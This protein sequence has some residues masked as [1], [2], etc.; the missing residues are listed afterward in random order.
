MPWGSISPLGYAGCCGLT[1]FREAIKPV[2]RKKIPI[3][4]RELIRSLNRQI[5]Q[6]TQQARLQLPSSAHE[7]KRLRGVQIH[8]RNQ[9]RL[10]SSIAL[11]PIVGC[12]PVATTTLLFPV[13]GAATVTNIDF[14]FCARTR[15]PTTSRFAARFSFGT[16]QV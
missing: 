5:H 4:S 7:I 15:L 14:R 13:Y 6:S 12:K 11:V 9:P 3:L 8:P 2:D 10:I 16:A 1:R